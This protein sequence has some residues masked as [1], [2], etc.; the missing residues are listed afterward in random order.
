MKLSLG[1]GC[2]HYTY[3]HNSKCVRKLITRPFQWHAA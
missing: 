3:R 1:N 2:I